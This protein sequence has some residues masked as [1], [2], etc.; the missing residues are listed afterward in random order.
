MVLN[1]NDTYV[2]LKMIRTAFDSQKLD[3]CFVTAFLDLSRKEWENFSRDTE[4]YLDRFNKILSTP[5]PLI[6]FIQD[7]LE[8]RIITSIEQIPDRRDRKIFTLVVPVDVDFLQTNIHAWKLLPRERGIMQSTP[9]QNLVKH[10]LH[11]PEHCIPEYTIVN[12]SKIDFLIMGIEILHSRSIMVSKMGWLDFGYFE[13]FVKVPMA[14][15]KFDN[16]DNSKINMIT[17][18]EPLNKYVDILLNLQ[19]A[20]DIIAGAFFLGGL[21]ALNEYRDLYH[22]QLERFSEKGIADDDQAVSLSVFFR[23]PEL[24]NLKLGLWKS[25]FDIFGAVPS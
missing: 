13:H 10:R 16:I 15:Y 7:H 1:I 22:D 9:Y 2:S 3:T 17:I 25:A 8:S 6:V 18:S 23:R 11:H 19:E 14:G 12:H 21:N 5:F 4:T 20:P 24:F